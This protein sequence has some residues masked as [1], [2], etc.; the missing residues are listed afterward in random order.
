ML[1][2]LCPTVTAH[3][4][5]DRRSV[6]LGGT[7]FGLTMYTG[8]VIVVNVDE[9]YDSPA[10]TAGV[11]SN[12]VITKANGKDVTSNEQLR[13]LIESSQGADIELS[14]MR[15][16]SPI[17]LSITPEQDDDGNYTAGM[18][19]RDS[20][21]GLGT[22][23]YYDPA[24]RS[25]GALGHGI[26]DRDTGM[27]LPLGRGRI[28]KAEISSVSKAQ[29]GVAGGLNG[30]MG[31]E[32][33]GEMT[34]NND[35]GVYGRYEADP[36]GDEIECALDSDIRT[37]EATVYTTTDGTGVHSYTVNIESI[38]LSD[39]SGQN[40]VL[41]VTDEEL[42]DATGGIVQGMSGSPIVQDGRL[43]GAVTHVFINSPEKGYGISI[44][45]MLSCSDRYGSVDIAA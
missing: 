42:L 3:A 18:W 39:N 29:K 27:L 24:T 41:R 32:V 11:R 4:E 40:M 25:F 2:L 34:L 35:Y 7:P 38:R 33:I 44:G 8:G 10:L 31:D 45:N 5:T 14:L 6:I 30:Y 22:V 1:L 21:A 13:Q 26:C 20:T 43:I 16:K 17:S 23:T 28:M 36:P 19:V 15:G 37:G 12:D 9:S